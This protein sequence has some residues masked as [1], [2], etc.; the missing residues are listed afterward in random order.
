MHNKQQVISIATE[1]MEIATRLSEHINNKGFNFRVANKNCI[2]LTGMEQVMLFHK[3]FL[4]PFNNLTPDCMKY[5]TTYVK[6]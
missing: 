1:N 6:I 5:K 4:E 3:R 2:T